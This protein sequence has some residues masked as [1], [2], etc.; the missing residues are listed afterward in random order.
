MLISKETLKNLFIEYF[1]S[2]PYTKDIKKAVERV[3]VVKIVGVTGNSKE[4]KIVV[5]SPKKAFK[6]GKPKTFLSTH[7]VKLNWEKKTISCTCPH[8]KKNGRICKLCSRGL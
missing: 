7:L 6:L 1:N 5:A 3:K 2:L 8:F 4:A